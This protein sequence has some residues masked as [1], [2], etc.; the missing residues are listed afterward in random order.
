MISTLIN[1]LQDNW[2][3]SLLLSE[4]FSETIFSF[5]NQFSSK[6]Q[7]LVHSKGMKLISWI[8]LSLINKQVEFLNELA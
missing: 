7:F 6:F 4:K 1:L 3:T 2:I 8:T 5:Q